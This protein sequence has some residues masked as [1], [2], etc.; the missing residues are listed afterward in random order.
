MNRKN[1]GKVLDNE[2]SLISKEDNK[3]NESPSI[4]INPLAGGGIAVAAATPTMA[5]NKFM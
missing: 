3:E 1:Q 5:R 4:G 2:K